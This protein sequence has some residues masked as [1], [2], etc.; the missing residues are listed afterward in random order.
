MARAKK[1]PDW[2]DFHRANMKE[3]D[4]L[5]RN[6]TWELA[7]RPPGAAILPTQMLNER[8]RGADGEIEKHKGRFVVCGNWQMAGRDYTDT[9]APVARYTT[10][11]MLLALVAKEDMSMYQLDVE[12]AFLNGPVEEELY[13]EQPRGYERGDPSK[14]CRL[15][16]ALYG[17]KQAARAWYDLLHKALSGMGLVRSEADPCLYVQ[18]RGKRLWLAVLVYVDDLLVVGVDEDETLEL[19]RNILGTFASRD[20]GEPTYFLGLHITR[21]RDVKTL[22]LSQQQYVKDLV[23]RHGQEDAYRVLLPMSVGAPLRGVGAPLDACGIKSYQELLGGL[24]YVATCARPDTSFA[25]GKLARFSSSPTVEHAGAATTVLRYLK[26]TAHRGLTYGGG[27]GL[28]GF[29]DADFAGDLDTRRSTSGFAFMYNGAAVGWRSKVQATVAT[30]TMEAEYIAA[31]AAA[32]EA[33]WLR[34]LLD[35]LHQAPGP[36]QLMCDN[37][38]AIRLAQSAGG[39]ARSKHIDVVYHFVRDRI[40]RGELTLVFIGTS[41]MV[42]DVLNKPLATAGLRACSIGLGLRDP[43]PGASKADARVGVLGL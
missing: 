38:G 30:S 36:P 8:K 16:K 34:K 9:W 2:P 22:T 32:R 42:A 10:L 29:T 21:N 23:A 27:A 4:S 41:G 3:V 35:D 19:K 31:A 1:E 11:R 7:T 37:Q 39:T 26:G 14:V 24:L 5:W 33:L 12:T 40:A 20:I 43:H 15:L 25:V 18:A 13:V 17:L 6:G 28:Q